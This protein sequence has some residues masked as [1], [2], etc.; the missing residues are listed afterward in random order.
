[1]LDDVIRVRFTHP[2][3]LQYLHKVA[4]KVSEMLRPDC[5]GMARDLP[6]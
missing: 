4:D 2:D 5:T 1:V 6:E 3:V